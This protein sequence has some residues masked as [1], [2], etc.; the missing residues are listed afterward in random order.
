MPWIP[1][2]DPMV[3]VTESQVFSVTIQYFELIGGMVDPVSG[4]ETPGTPVYYNV[5]VTPQI[6]DPSTITITGNGT[7]EVTISGYYGP[8]FNDQ[9]K[10]MLTYDVVDP[11]NTA[12]PT[13]REYT[14]TGTWANFASYDDNF[15]VVS[16]IPDQTRTRDLYY[17]LSL[18][19]I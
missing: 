7:T 2:S 16:F 9:I 1:E 14:G 12:E 6:E 19:H 10:S 13:Y 18:I 3:T 15:E 5:T 4:I 11:T 8:V 17:T